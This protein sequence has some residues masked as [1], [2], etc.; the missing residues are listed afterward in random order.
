MLQ[1]A[2]SIAA[3]LALG[4]ITPAG[5]QSAVP[6]VSA[7]APGDR[8]VAMV[9]VSRLPIDLRRIERNFRQTTIREE[10]DGLNLRYFVDVFAKAPPIVIIR[11]EDN[12]LYGPAPYGAPS[13][14]D[15]LQMMTPREFRASGMMLGSGLGVPRKKTNDGR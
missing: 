6:P 12:V 7:P 10:R 3:I 15:M 8:V 1:R 4:T 14:R 5:A 13:H 11:P 2:L 9:D